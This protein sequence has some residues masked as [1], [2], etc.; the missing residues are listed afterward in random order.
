M[1]KPDGKKEKR[2]QSTLKRE[3]TG[4]VRVETKRLL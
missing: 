1:Q 2:K 4:D 3:E